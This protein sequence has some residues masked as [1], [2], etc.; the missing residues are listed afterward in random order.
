MWVKEATGT[1]ILRS[2]TSRTEEPG[3]SPLT[4]D[5]NSAHFHQIIG[6]TAL[7]LYRTQLS[8]GLIDLS[9]GPPNNRTLVSENWLVGQV[10]I[11][12]F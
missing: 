4:L 1:A 12:S 5:Q 6:E 3:R 11:V 9:F 8:A 7:V 10:K 2:N